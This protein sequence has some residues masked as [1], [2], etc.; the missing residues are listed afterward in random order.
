MDREGIM[1]SEKSQTKK[2]TVRSLPSMGNL[3]KRES[4]THR[5]REQTG[6]CQ[7]Q[8]V[9]LEK[10]GTVVKRYKLP[11]KIVTTANNAVL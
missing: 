11:V 1:V 2:N 7:S 10:W 8:G 4:Q 3:K 5:N 6:G 9:G